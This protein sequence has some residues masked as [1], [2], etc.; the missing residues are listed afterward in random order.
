M[1]CFLCRAKCGNGQYCSRRATASSYC[2]QHQKRGGVS[3]CLGVTKKGQRCLNWVKDGSCYCRLHTPD[4]KESKPSECPVCVESFGSED[5]HLECGHWVHKACVVKSGKAECPMCRRRLTRLSRSDKDEMNRI[6]AQRR[7]D[8]V[9]EM[10]LTLMHEFLE[11][12]MEEVRV[13]EVH[14]GDD[15]DIEALIDSVNILSDS[16]ISVSASNEQS[17][18]RFLEGLVARIDRYEES[19]QDP[20]TPTSPA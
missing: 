14:I 6:K 15:D 4:F 10:T 3:T 12:I 2:F 8:E 7:I 17:L 11:S 16:N 5:T 18:T 9:N 13:T 19:G 20:P 1:N